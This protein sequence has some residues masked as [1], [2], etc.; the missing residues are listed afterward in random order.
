MGGE[1][2]KGNFLESVMKAFVTII[3]ETLMEAWVD[4][5]FENILEPWM[6]DVLNP[7]MDR[8]I[9]SAQW[10]DGDSRALRHIFFCFCERLCVQD[11]PSKA[12]DCLF[13]LFGHKNPSRKRQ[14]VPPNSP[15][16]STWCHLIH[17]KTQHGPQD[18]PNMGQTGN[19]RQGFG[20]LK[21]F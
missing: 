14:H 21:R 4:Q 8:M 1:D 18:P 2:S 11:G 20:I 7:W 6:H 10:T 3:M 13:C 9:H 16:A 5:W 15:V 12:S 19:P 17:L